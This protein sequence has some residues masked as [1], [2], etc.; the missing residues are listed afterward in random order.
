MY[1]SYNE[2]SNRA[3]LP[4]YLKVSRNTFVVEPPRRLHLDR[5][6]PIKRV[7]PGPP[8]YN[9]TMPRIT[10]SHSLSQRS[11]E[12]HNGHKRAWVKLEFSFERQH[13]SLVKPRLSRFRPRRPH[14]LV[15]ILANPPDDDRWVH[16]VQGF[17][18]H[19]GFPLD[20][21]PS[22]SGWQFA[23]TSYVKWG[24]TRA[25]IGRILDRRKA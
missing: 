19:R 20:P 13:G 22:G 6:K 8:T 5:P 1:S 4:F 7:A 3:R 12:T 21:D 16:C 17:T 24:Y 25:R 9:I 18:R 10:D 23:G 14:C 15:P 11:Y 2:L